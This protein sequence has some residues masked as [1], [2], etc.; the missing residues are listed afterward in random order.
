[1]FFCLSNKAI[2]FWKIILFVQEINKLKKLKYT[3]Q[4]NY[5]KNII[6]SKINKFI[7]HIK[8]GII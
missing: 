6:F 7:N 3:F 2:N 1:M 5:Q 8:L 4:I